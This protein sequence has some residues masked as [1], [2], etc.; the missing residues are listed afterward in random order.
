M[1]KKWKQ[2]QILF[3]WAPRSS[4][5]MTPDVKLKDTCSWKKSYDK[6]RHSI[7]KQRHHFA[8]KGPYSQSYS[9]SVSHVPTWELDQKKSEH[10][11]ID[12]FELRCWRRLL[13][14]PWA[15]RRLNQSKYSLEGLLLK[16][17]LQ[18]FGH[19]IR[20]ASSLEKT[21]MPAKIESRRRG[22]QGWHGWMASPTWW[23]WA[24]TNSRRLWR[25]GKPGVLKFMGLQRV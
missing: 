15:A 10:R 14:L 24:W 16:S 23:I 8:D 12:T 2:C 13:T 3:S 18:Y 9:F 21:L 4:Q 1:G 11:R 25:T 22:R 5:M 17:K 20:R 7:I 19:L 6:R